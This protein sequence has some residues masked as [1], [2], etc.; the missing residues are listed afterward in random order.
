MKI[1]ILSLYSRFGGKTGDCV[2]AE[3]TTI[4]LRDL[5]ESVNRFFL[6]PETKEV[7]DE[8]GQLVGCWRDAMCD[9]DIVHAIPPIP[10]CY[11]PR[12]DIRAKFVAS[13]VFWRS[14]TYTRVV[15]RNE[16][17][18]SRIILQD[19]IRTFF[20]WMGIPTYRSY[21]RYDLLLPNS[22][23]EIDCFK[24]YCRI[25]KGARIVAVPNAIDPIPE[26][27]ERLPRSNKVPVGDYIL[28]PAYFAPR[29]NQLALI[30]AL[31]NSKYPVVFIGEG[32][33]FARCKNEANSNMLF[34]GHI[35]HR[36]D[37]FYSIMR[38]ARICCLP[39]NCETPGIAALESAALG[40]RPVVPRE[41]GTTQYY[42]W[43]A[44]YLDPLSK[45][46]IKEAVDEAW[47]L[48]RLTEA[49]QA[50]YKDLVWS[51]CARKTLAAYKSAIRM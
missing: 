30:R 39:S 49:R 25:K 47:E 48:G 26:H 11:L 50:M 44:T 27:I 13:T 1:A 40:V 14:L 29:K 3:K 36:S 33:S 2:Q 37:E 20:A 51:L 22:I 4:A 46:S 9:V 16:G 34:L 41:G 19:Y 38:D 15:G 12:E 10:S 42:G 32:P 18:L 23:D 24:R 45:D 31:R 5:G 17:R 35:E 7:Y 43:D 6:R 28:V 8:S 21:L